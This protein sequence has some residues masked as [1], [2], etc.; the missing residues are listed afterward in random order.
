MLVALTGASGFI[1]SYIARAL[2]G[3]GHQVRALVRDK[4]RTE[5]EI[6][7]GR[8]ATAEQLEALVRELRG[9]DA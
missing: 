1:G 6:V 7:D 3:A 9:D 8:G 5:H 4:V 2:H